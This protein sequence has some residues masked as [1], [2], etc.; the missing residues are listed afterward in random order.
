MVV[1]GDGPLEMTRQMT[2]AS[3]GLPRK[4]SP[5]IVTGHDSRTGVFASVGGDAVTFVLPTSFPER[6]TS[7]VHAKDPDAETP[8]VNATSSAGMPAECVLWVVGRQGR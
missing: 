2:R 6:H 4:V 3:E 7:T 1:G 8:T 5:V